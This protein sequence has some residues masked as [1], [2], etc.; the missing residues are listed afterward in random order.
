[1]RD[2]PCLSEGE[3]S[4]HFVAVVGG[5]WS[6]LDTLTPLLRLLPGRLTFLRTTGRLEG[7]L[8]MT[9]EQLSQVSYSISKLTTMAP[10]ISLQALDTTLE[11]IKTVRPGLWPNSV[12]PLLTALSIG[13]GGSGYLTRWVT[14]LASLQT[15]MLF[16]RLES[17]V[18]ALNEDLMNQEIRFGIRTIS[19]ACPVSPRY[20]TRLVARSF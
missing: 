6:G 10:G 3:V 15:Q 16:A 2:N 17:T 12:I 4:V 11:F 13:C 5:N 1:M 20:L 18:F 7:S 8:S 19:V 14:T 9:Q